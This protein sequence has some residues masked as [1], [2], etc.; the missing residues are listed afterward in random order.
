MPTHVHMGR[1]QMINGDPIYRSRGI[2]QMYTEHPGRANKKKKKGERLA[3][4]LNILLNGKTAPSQ[5]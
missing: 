5:S 3:G 4:R 2:K 1:L